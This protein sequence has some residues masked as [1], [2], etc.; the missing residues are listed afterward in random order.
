[1]AASKT[2]KQAAKK[3]ITA[4]PAEKNPVWTDLFNMLIGLGI[5]ALATWVLIVVVNALV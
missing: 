4:K 3:T 5:I 1:M 2:Q